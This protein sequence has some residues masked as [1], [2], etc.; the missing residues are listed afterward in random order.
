M[1]NIFVVLFALVIISCNN[2]PTAENKNESTDSTSYY[3]EKI[4]EEGA[5]TMVDL[6][7][8]MQ[9]K[10]EGTY[11]VSGTI[12]ECCQK[13]GCWM[14]LDKGDG[15][16][17]RVTF[18]DYGFFVP[19]ESAGK[20]VVIS[21][22]AYLDTTSVEYLREYASDEGKSKEEIEKINEPKIELAFEADGVIIK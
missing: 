6:L 7:S 2:Q 19:L 11:K 15:T 8:Q 17:M 4:S 10:A 14:T 18:K 20:Q 21:G 22:K 5:I 13:K 9:G 3:G 16:E 12:K 1:K